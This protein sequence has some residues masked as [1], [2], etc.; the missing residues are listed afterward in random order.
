MRDERCERRRERETISYERDCGILLILLLLSARKAFQNQNDDEPSS[1]G[2][3]V[4]F[5]V[6]KCA[7]VICRCRL[8]LHHF[9]FKSRSFTL[10]SFSPSFFDAFQKYTHTPITLHIYA[11]YIGIFVALAICSIN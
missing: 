2:L 11:L 7:V 9:K 4:A 10:N 8:R 5:F 6:P 1:F 3:A